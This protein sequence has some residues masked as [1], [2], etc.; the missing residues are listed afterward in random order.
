[1]DWKEEITVYI[2]NNVNTCTQQELSMP[3][4]KKERNFTLFSIEIHGLD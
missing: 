3:R 2:P 4:R 1:V